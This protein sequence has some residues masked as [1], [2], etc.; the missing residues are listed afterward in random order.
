MGMNLTLVKKPLQRD[1][2]CR[3]LE[4]IPNNGHKTLIPVQRE[5]HRVFERTRED[6]ENTMGGRFFLAGHQQQRECFFACF[7][8]FS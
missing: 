7:N 3:L 4:R 2:L 1:D 6:G 5:L 8:Q